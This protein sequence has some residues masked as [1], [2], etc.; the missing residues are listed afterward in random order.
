MSEDAPRDSDRVNLQRHFSWPMTPSSMT[1]SKERRHVP[2]RDRLKRA[3][4]GKE[5][6]FVA[7]YDDVHSAGRGAGS[8]DDPSVAALRRLHDIEVRRRVSSSHAVTCSGIAGSA[9]QL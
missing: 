7:A 8:V 2:L 9:L 1:F 3:S 5:D 4:T 6:N